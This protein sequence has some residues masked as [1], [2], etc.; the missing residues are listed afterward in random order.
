MR[1]RFILAARHDDKRN[2]AP[3][4]AD[5]GCACTLACRNS[6]SRILAPFFALAVI[7]LSF[8]CGGDDECGSTAACAGPRA[9]AGPDLTVR[10]DLGIDT[11]AGG[12]VDAGV[13][14]DA[15]QIVSTTSG[16]RWDYCITAGQ[17]R[18]RD[19]STSG[20]TEPGIIELGMR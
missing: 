17:M 15:D 8:G 11:D 14:I 10:V 13:D 18:Y 9:D 20:S 7:T 12:D 1:S 19:V 16:K 6:S 5:A 3:G 2:F 4:F